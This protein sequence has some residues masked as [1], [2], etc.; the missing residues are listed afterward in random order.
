MAREYVCDLPMTLV[1]ASCNLP[2]A[3][4]TS[5]RVTIRAA[6]TINSHREY[7]GVRENVTK[8][9]KVVEKLNALEAEARNW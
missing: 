6:F 1:T 9:F 4:R 3:D 5:K 8:S 2:N 7:N